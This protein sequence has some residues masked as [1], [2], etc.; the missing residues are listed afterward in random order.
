MCS[1]IGLS[2]GLVPLYFVIL[3]HNKIKLSIGCYS[4]FSFPTGTSEHT[5]FFVGIVKF[6]YSEKHA[7]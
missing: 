6:V 4:L 1:R 2:Q 7:S 5:F 3:G